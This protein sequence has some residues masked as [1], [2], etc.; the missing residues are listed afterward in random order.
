[1]YAKK[2]TRLYVV[3]TTILNK[4]FNCHACHGTFLYFIKEYERFSRNKRSSRKSRNSGNNLSCRPALLKNEPGLRLEQEIEFHKMR[5]VFFCKFAYYER[6]SY[7]AGAINKQR[8]FLRIFF[9]LKEFLGDGPFQHT[10]SVTF[11]RTGSN[12]FVT[13]FWLLHA[14]FVTFFRVVSITFVTFF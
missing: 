13:F 12:N 5:I 2:R 14:Y 4:R 6:L 11:F 8:L 7:L 10:H 3:K 1:M 9:P